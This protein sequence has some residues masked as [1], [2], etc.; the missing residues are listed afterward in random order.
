MIVRLKAVIFGADF[1]KSEKTLFDNFVKS[2]EFPG[3][4]KGNEAFLFISGLQNQLL[5][6]LNVEEVDKLMTRNGNY[7]Q[8]GETRIFDSRRMRLESGRW[9]PMMLGN[10][11]AQAGIKLERVK[12]FQDQFK[13]MQEQKRKFRR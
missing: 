4:L 3:H 7:T 8:Y 5:W 10:Y 6:I 9:N 11:A 1:R 2:K 13:E 12:M